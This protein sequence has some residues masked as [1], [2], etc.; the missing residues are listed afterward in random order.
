[1]RKDISTSTFMMVDSPGM[2]DSPVTRASPF[3]PAT[4]PGGRL[5]HSLTDRGYDFEAVVKWF[6]DRADVILLFFDPDKPGTTG[7]TLSILTNS[8][9]GL[10]HKL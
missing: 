8:L 3:D 4:G 6:A 10:D 1:V 5:H 9:P 2:I 7:E